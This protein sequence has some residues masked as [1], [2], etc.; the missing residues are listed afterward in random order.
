MISDCRSKRHV[1]RIDLR[2]LCNLKIQKNARLDG[3]AL[4][5]VYGLLKAKG[6]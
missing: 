5:I 4:G 2:R 1:A 6:K 3:L